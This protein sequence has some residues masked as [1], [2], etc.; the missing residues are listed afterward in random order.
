MQ[1]RRHLSAL[2]SLSFVLACRK[3]PPPAAETTPS[4]TAPSASASAA[5]PLPSSVVAEK[6]P[7]FD[8]DDAP[9]ASAKPQVRL[10][11]TVTLTGTFDNVKVGTDGECDAVRLPSPIRVLGKAGVEAEGRQVRE[12]CL[13]TWVDSM[14]P[15]ALQPGSRIIVRGSVTPRIRSHHPNAIFLYE[16]VV[17]SASP[18]AIETPAGSLPDG[19]SFGYVRDVDVTAR[20]VAFDV[21]YLY[22]GD[23][24]HR[25]ARAHGTKMD[26]TGANPT[27]DYFIVNDSPEVRTVH[28]A[29]AKDFELRRLEPSQGG[30]GGWRIYALEELRQRSAS[31][32]PYFVTLKGGIASELRVVPFVH[33]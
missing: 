6:P 29:P 31:E 7:A 3:T 18:P 12:L 22:F 26:E 33:P 8:G 10:G 30:G 2:V 19:V 27:Q 9:D 15:P 17:V 13:W 11:D 24:A 5:P 28:I 20:T 25:A 14:H 4:A 23:A 1:R 21:A 16:T 32:P